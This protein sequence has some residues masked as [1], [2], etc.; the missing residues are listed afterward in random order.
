MAIDIDKVAQEAIDAI[1]EK[2]KN[3]NTLN[4][5]VAGKTGVG[6]STLINAVF[7]DKLAETGMGKPV[8]DHMRKISKKG[9]PLAIYDTKG[10]ELG[11]EVQQQVK[12]EVMETISKGLATQDINKA[13]H[14]IWYCINTA[15]NRVEPEEIEW[16]KELSRENQI[17]QVPIIVVLTQSFSKKNADAMRKMI[18]DENLDI[19][20]VVPVLAED[21][22]ID[23]EYI[24]KS[25]GL[26]VL[27][28]VMGEALPDELMDTLQNVQ[29]ASLA[30]K[31]KRARAA[32]ATATLAAAGEGAAPIPFSDC[33][34]L[35][36]TQLGMIASITVIFGFDINKSILTAFLSSTLG[37]G[38]ATLLGKTVVSNLVKLI[39]GVG[40][41]AGGA[42]SAA[43][44]GAL[45]AALGEAY[46]GIMTLVFNGEMS[47]D[48]LGTK[49]GKDQMTALFKHELK[50]KR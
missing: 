48:D 13:I 33:A 26:D 12:Q 49:R 27:I 23:E 39:P 11:K 20:Q 19:V 34:L 42:I 25:Y 46:I 44:A 50:K 43:T 14:C 16:L 41:V 36:P 18:L 15:S 30:E 6:K 29:I 24:A 8:T 38:G 40:T 31:K 5:I 47:I 28:H 2:I 32:I 9:I 22:E 37:S 21:Y 35:I 4:I 3:L 45:T 10:F 1:S 7:R 17:T